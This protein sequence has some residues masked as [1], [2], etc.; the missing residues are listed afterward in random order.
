[1]VLLSLF[2]L[3][4]SEFNLIL[5]LL[6]LCLNKVFDNDQG[7]YERVTSTEKRGLLLHMI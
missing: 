3:A 2:Y 4:F 5:V 7:L 6:S 1:M